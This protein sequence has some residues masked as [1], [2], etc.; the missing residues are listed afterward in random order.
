MQRA[1]NGLQRVDGVKRIAAQLG[2]RFGSPV[3]CQ[4]DCNSMPFTEMTVHPNE[5]ND[6]VCVLN[7]LRPATR[8]VLY[9]WCMYMDYMDIYNILCVID[10]IHN[11]STIHALSMDKD[12]RSLQQQINKIGARMP[13]VH[14]EYF[15]CY[16]GVAKRLRHML[17]PKK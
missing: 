9:L 17:S 4:R 12:V 16:T 13:L 7:Q 14:A 11:I 10:M 15:P 8:D 3:P 2:M 1:K 5:W 6:V